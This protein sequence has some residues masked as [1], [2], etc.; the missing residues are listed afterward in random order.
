[1]DDFAF[2]RALNEGRPYFGPKYAC[3]QGRPERHIY[4]RAL[5][6]QMHVQTPAGPLNILEIG[7]W[8]GGSAIT[9]AR[10]LQ[11]T[12][13]TGYVCCV[14]SWAQY[15]D[16]SVDRDPVYREMNAGAAN[17][18]IVRIFHH[19]IRVCGVADRVIA[20]KGR[21]EDILPLLSPQTFDV[22][23]VDGSHRYDHVVTDIRL[24]RPLLKDS[25][26][27]CGDDFELHWN[28][29]DVT[30]LDEAVATDA[31]YV[32]LGGTSFHPGVTA[33]V[34]DALGFVSVYDGVWMTQ[35]RSGETRP[36]ALMARD[37]TIPPHL[38]PLESDIAPSHLSESDNYTILQLGARF[39]AVARS[40]GPIDLMREPVGTR[41][42]P[43]LLLID[44]DEAR[45]RARVAT[46]EYAN[47]PSFEVVEQRNTHMLVRGGARVYAVAR[48]L[49]H[50]DL[51]FER[52][53]E[54]EISDVLLID[55]D[56][57]RLRARLSEI[58]KTSYRPT[59]ELIEERATHV[60][61]RGGSKVYAIARCLGHVDLFS[62][63]LGDRQL[64]DILLIDD[65]EDRLRLRLAE[66]EDG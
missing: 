60:L 12:G 21:S 4:L 9:W 58:E 45:L 65:D 18:D 17:G 5:V 34:R 26:V 14:D 56:E 49:G 33:G 22:I 31:D 43:P 3:A 39:V 42:F 36:I 47:R 44:A 57:L 40:L 24:S 15:F 64:A 11:A 55:T 29:C 1:M 27:L 8:A 66:I 32:T 2:C 62:E 7:S 25:G 6:E 38:T 23:F 61:V 13:R 41:E 50:V 19:N 52:L 63:R 53:G 48:S 28:D 37:S 35:I 16:L 30:D 20:M 46:L 51:L 10:A 54:R 59:L